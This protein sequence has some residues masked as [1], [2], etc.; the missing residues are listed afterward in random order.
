MFYNARWY[1]PALGRFA[2]ADSIVPGGVQGLDRYAYVNNNPLRYNDPTGHMCM[3]PEA[4][5]GAAGCDGAD[6][7]GQVSH[8]GGLDIKSDTN[9][10][11]NDDQGFGDSNNKPDCSGRYTCTV[12]E[13]TMTD[14]DLES[15]IS[16]S[17]NMRD[18]SRKSGAA[19]TT[20]A[21]VALIGPGMALE[22]SNP[23]TCVAYI[24][25][26]GGSIAVSTFAGEVGGN[27]AGNYY[28][29]INDKL[30]DVRSPQ[31]E[32]QVNITTRTYRDVV[33]PGGVGIDRTDFYLQIDNSEPIS[34]YGSIGN[35]VLIDLFGDAP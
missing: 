17:R 23:I 12:T 14:S 20:A 16:K 3:D 32:H 1:D 28:S 30:S 10:S 35:Q 26:G 34:L 19:W 21:A 25:Y 7:V 2:Q 8:G 13:Q 5:R 11:N 4:N 27:V 6:R 22:C 24:G 9:S 29:D 15:L 31:T 33:L 18:I